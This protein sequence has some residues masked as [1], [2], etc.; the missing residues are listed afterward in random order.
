MLAS[1][2]ASRMHRRCHDLSNNSALTSFCE[3]SGFLIFS[4]LVRGVYGFLEALRD[5]ALEVVR[6]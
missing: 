2:A 4:H 6:T 5:D 1:S 3:Q